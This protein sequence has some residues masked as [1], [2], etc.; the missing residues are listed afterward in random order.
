[1]WEDLYNMKFDLE[2]VKTLE[3]KYRFVPFLADLHTAGIIDQETYDIMFNG[4][5]DE[6]EN[7]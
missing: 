7:L 6:H 2:L 1:M 3:K 4:N 5:M